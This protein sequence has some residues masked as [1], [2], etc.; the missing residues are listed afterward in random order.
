[1]NAFVK[2]TIPAA[3]LGLSLIGAAPPPGDPPQPP[4][5]SMPMP[6]AEKRAPLSDA[7][8]LMRLDSEADRAKA[9]GEL[10]VDKASTP[11]VKKLGKDVSQGAHDAK[12]RVETTAK[13][14]GVSLTGLEA[15][16]KEG[17]DSSIERLRGLSGIAFDK[18]VVNALH[19][20]RAAVADL[21]ADSAANATP[22]DVKSLAASLLPGVEQQRDQAQRLMHEL[23]S[24]PS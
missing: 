24:R 13:T 23:A 21:L 16:P 19:A 8:I 10:A 7:Q 14:V 6:A 9:L 12:A 20:N 18:A 3:I 5:Q 4:A 2:H 17:M 15:A 1:M 22:N 11:E